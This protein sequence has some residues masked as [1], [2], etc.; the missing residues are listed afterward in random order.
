M[1]AVTDNLKF[2]TVAA[3][4]FPV[5]YVS[6]FH[7]QKMVFVRAN[8]NEIPLDTLFSLVALMRENQWKNYPLRVFPMALT[9]EQVCNPFYNP[10]GLEVIDYPVDFD[11]ATLE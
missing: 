8:G 1:D 3:P 11:F 5:Y 9:A 6:V 7:K 4:T 10:D 2:C